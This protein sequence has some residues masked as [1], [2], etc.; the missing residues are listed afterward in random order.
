MKFSIRDLLLVTVIVALAVG[1]I[2]DHAQMNHKMQGI[3]RLYK[4]AAD[5]LNAITST[6][7][8]TVILAAPNSSS[9]APIPPKP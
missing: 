4:S 8:E 6:R 3:M 5:R 9:P 1:W 7:E 2:A